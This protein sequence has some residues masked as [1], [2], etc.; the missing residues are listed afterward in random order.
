MNSNTHVK[1]SPLKSCLLINVNKSLIQKNRYICRRFRV[2]RII[3]C[4]MGR[5]LKCKAWL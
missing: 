4:L 5:C 1:K 2:N 3:K